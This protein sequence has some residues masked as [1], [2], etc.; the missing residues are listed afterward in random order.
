MP[1][2]A[3]ALLR[4]QFSQAKFVL[5][6]VLNDCDEALLAWLPDGANIQTGATILAHIVAD[7]DFL[8]NA[9]ALNRPMVIQTG[10]WAQRAGVPAPSGPLMTGDWIAGVNLNL[11]GIRDYA[12]EVFA[13][14]D[15]GLAN[16]P[17]AVLD[18][19][20]E[21]PM[22]KIT[23]LQFLGTIGVYQIA[24]HTGEIAALKGIQGKRGLPF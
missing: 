18:A 1:M 9:G 10:D 5:D 17:D 23:T 16:A 6:L 15:E 7:A 11:A 20:R 8:V 14:I 19:E 21:T 24:E 4:S 22:G 3:R 12:N 13:S 2:D